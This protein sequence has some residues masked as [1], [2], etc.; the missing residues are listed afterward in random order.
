MATNNAINNSLPSPFTLGATSVTS[1]GTQLNLLNASTVVPFNKV[2]VQIFTSSGTYTPTAG[3]VYCHV[4]ECGGGGGSGGAASTTSQA[5]ASGGGQAGGYNEAWFTAATVGVSQTVTIGAAGTAGT[6][7]TAG[8]NGGNTSFGALLT[9]NG[10]NG[11]TN[12]TTGTA[13]ISTGGSGGGTTS[14][15]AGIFAIVGQ[16]GQSG[17]A[18]VTTGTLYVVGSGGS[19]PLGLGAFGV[20]GAGNPATNGVVGTGY[21]SG[22]S[23]AG[24]GGTA[25]AA[26]GAAGTAGIVIVTEFLNA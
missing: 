8:G 5:A 12:A 3:M 19:N 13:I 26:A 16:S 21:G 10:G 2:A 15:G 24:V 11:S 14:T 22:A 7:S 25:G 6:S 17:V 4:R 23:G 9:A 1:T 20:S 18:F